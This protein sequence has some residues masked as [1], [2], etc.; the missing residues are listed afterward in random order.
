MKELR[1]RFWLLIGLLSIFLLLP[2]FGFAEEEPHGDPEIRV[3]QPKLFVKGLRLEVTPRGG[4]I[5]NDPFINT[6]ALGGDLFFH[7]NEWLAVGGFYQQTFTSDSSNTEVL[8]GAPFSIEADRSEINRLMF[9]ELQWSPIYNKGSVMGRKVLH[10]DL[11]FSAGVG[12]VDSQL[13]Y[14]IPKTATQEDPKEK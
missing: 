8:R 3:I 13:S 7:I 10:Y 12:I 14:T 4:P 5:L 9:G 11:Y 6:F 2:L 1:P